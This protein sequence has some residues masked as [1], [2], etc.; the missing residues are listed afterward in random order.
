MNIKKAWL[1]F[2]VYGAILLISVAALYMLPKGKLIDKHMVNEKVIQQAHNAR[3]HF[4]DAISSGNIEGIDGI[5]SAGSWSFE[6][7]SKQLEIISPGNDLSN[8]MIVVDQK[9]ADD[10]K[11]EI[12]HYITKTIVDSIDMTD[13]IDYSIDI[14]LDN[15]SLVIT[16]PVSQTIEFKSFSKDFYIKQFLNKSSS[17]SD[18]VRNIR[19]GDFMGESA[20]F[21]RVPK[22]LEVTGKGIKV[23]NDIF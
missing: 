1:I 21:L 8:I 5:Y 11:I 22:G 20:I 13:M 15:G 16:P 4:Y 2:S 6:Y 14:K 12:G 10:N 3:M 9:D 18:R 17:A 7:N 23:K 19:N